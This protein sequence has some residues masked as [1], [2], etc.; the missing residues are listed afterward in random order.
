MNF[1]SFF[2]TIKKAMDSPVPKSIDM[3]PQEQAEIF[4]E[5]FIKTKA[6]KVKPENFIPASVL[7]LWGNSALNEND[8]QL[9]LIERGQDVHLHQGEIGLPGGRWEESDNKI[10]NKIKGAKIDK[11][12]LVWTALRETHEEV[13]IKH[14]DINVLGAL[15]PLDTLFTGFRVTPV[16]GCLKCNI[17]EISL[18]LDPKEVAS[19]F[20]VPL[21]DFTNDNNFCFETFRFGGEEF[22]TAVFYVRGGGHRVWG[23]TAVIIFSF[24]IL[25][26]MKRP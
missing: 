15:Y 12:G 22:K 18:T 19:A 21:S 8:P 24:L 16:V 6:G 17:E 7:M 14:C 25:M 5:R 26:D 4:L 3:L 9:L 11:P 1:N 13:G 2:I 10:I 23:A 20:W